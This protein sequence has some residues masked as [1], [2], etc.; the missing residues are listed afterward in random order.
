MLSNHFLTNDCKDVIFSFILFLCMYWFILLQW[1]VICFQKRAPGAHFKVWSWL[2]ALIWGSVVWRGRSLKISKF[3]S[4]PYLI[5]I[6][7]V[8]KQSTV[9]FCR[10][11]KHWFSHQHSYQ[12]EN[13]L[14]FVSLMDLTHLIGREKQTFIARN[15]IL[16]SV[17]M[18]S[19]FYSSNK[20]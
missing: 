20:V 7:P 14:S 16:L 18:V 17:R 15:H 1:N 3:D 9:W 19:C 13:R 10:S 4:G 11:L 2:R 8:S 12:M 5:H 6:C